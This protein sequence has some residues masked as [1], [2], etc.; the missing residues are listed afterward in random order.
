MH[1]LSIYL[2]KLTARIHFKRNSITSHN[3]VYF[4]F[5]HVIRNVSNKSRLETCIVVSSNFIG[6][7]VVSVINIVVPLV[8]TANESTVKHH[9]VGTRVA[10]AVVAILRD[11][12]ARA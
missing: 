7:V 8:R 11:W 3:V 9:R 6:D 2:K 12:W 5:L 10:S 4:S 1:V